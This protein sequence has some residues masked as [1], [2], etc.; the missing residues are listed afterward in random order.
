MLWEEYI[1]LLGRTQIEPFDSGRLNFFSVLNLLMHLVTEV[2]MLDKLGDED[3][4]DGSCSHNS[5]T[6]S[7]SAALPDLINTSKSCLSFIAA[8]FG[9]S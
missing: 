1:P 9:G 3:E 6:A 5:T 2:R 8:Q 4:V 7:I